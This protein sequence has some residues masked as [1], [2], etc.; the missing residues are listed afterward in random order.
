M[1]NPQ[2]IAREQASA[3]FAVVPRLPVVPRGTSPKIAARPAPVDWLAHRALDVA[4]A[5]LALLVLAPP[6]L[7]LALLIKLTSRGPALYRQE[8]G[9]GLDGKPFT[10]YKFRTM[11]VE[12]RG[13]HGAGV[14]QTRR[15]PP[16][17]VG[18]RV[19]AAE[20]R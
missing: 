6:M 17:A 11:R 4:V 7:L 9:T 14:G 20:P 10:M 3:L 19:A 18:H 2:T 12:R 13:P 16:H 1:N 15:S 8:S 5:S